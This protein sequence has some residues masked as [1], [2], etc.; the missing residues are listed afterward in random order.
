MN[1]GSDADLVQA[2]ASEDREA[3][4]LLYD[5]YAARL[6]G[7]AERILGRKSEAEDL[8]HDLFIEVRQQA[9]R[10]DRERGS[11]A[12]WLTLRLR[13]RALDRLR[14]PAYRRFVDLESAGYVEPVLSAEAVAAESEREP[15]HRAL[16]TSMQALSDETRTILQLVYFKGRSLPE[17]AAELNLP[18]GTVKSRLHRSLKALRDTVKE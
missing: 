3:L 4:S 15:L 9:H 8:L 10:Y 14:S 7:L 18:L 12:S 5:R 13:C 2:I 1:D 11:V 6:L 17:V 16:H